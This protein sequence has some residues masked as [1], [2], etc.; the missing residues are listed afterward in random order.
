M[1]LFSTILLS[2]FAINLSIGQT[3]EDFVNHVKIDSL[4]QTVRELSGEDSVAINNQMTLLKNRVYNVN[5]EA[6][7]YI[8]Q[9]LE[10]Y[11]LTVNDQVY[12]NTGRNVIA[13]QTGINYPDS[14]LLMCAHYDAVTDYAADDNASGVAAVIEAARI[15]SKYEFSH[16][17]VY[18]LWDEEE[19]GLYGST[20]YA[21][22]AN[23]NDEQ[24]IGVLNFEMF[25]YDSN[26]DGLFDIHA[27]EDP[28][29]LRLANTTVAIN[30]EFNFN[31]DPVVYNPGTIY[32]DHSPFWNNNYGAIM[33]IQAYYGDDFSSAYHTINDRI[34]LFN[35]DYF[36]NLSKLSI[37]VAA[38]LA[39]PESTGTGS[40]IIFT[41]SNLNLYPN[42]ATESITIEYN[43]SCNVELINSYGAVV[44]SFTLNTSRNIDLSNLSKGIYFIKIKDEAPVVT[45]FV[46]N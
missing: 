46:K 22:Q 14:V 20:H 28:V 45:K 7:E 31:L 15:F 37:G 44:K 2:L 23:V 8:I 11:G 10:N 25:G 42:P 24:I 32:S 5:D 3:V 30:D 33:I 4:V 1:K 40:D 9:R 6:A 34:N 18:A 41:Q 26:D 13:T 38:S 19:I 17:I 43:K 21:D 36:E 27:N 29:S 16:T 39:I 35:I 12:S